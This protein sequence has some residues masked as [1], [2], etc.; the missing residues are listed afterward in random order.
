MR[1]VVKADPAGKQPPI[2]VDL[3]RFRSVLCRL[4]G[5][6]LLTTF[7]QRIDVKVN[8]IYVSFKSTIYV[9]WMNQRS[10]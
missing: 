3:G 5:A 1:G 6:R 4:K 2:D 9:D 7:G 8:R 10:R